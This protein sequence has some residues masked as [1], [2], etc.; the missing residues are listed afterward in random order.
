MLAKDGWKV[1]TY[2]LE[3]AEILKET[4]N[5][6]MAE[7][8][9]DAEKDVDVLLGG[10]PFSSNGLYINDPFSQKNITVQ[11]VF[12]KAKGK[13]VE[14]K[15]VKPIEKQKEFVG[16]LQKWDENMVY[17]QIEENKIEIER[18]NISLMK[19]KYNWN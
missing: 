11:E 3:N 16:I 2:G 9:Q 5:V 15:L 14:I 8:L 6:I 17:L 10:V 19:L 4:P 18:K 1:Y 7:N 13:E 12:E